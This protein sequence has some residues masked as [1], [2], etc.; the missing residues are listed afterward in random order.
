MSQ[1][2]TIQ[3]PQ[4]HYSALGAWLILAAMV[5]VELYVQFAPRDHAAWQQLRFQIMTDYG[6]MDRKF[7]AWLAGGSSRGLLPMFA[8]YLFVHDGA[9]QLGANGAL[10]LFVAPFLCRYIDAT[11]LLILFLACGFVGVIAFGLTN[12]ISGPLV[13]GSAAAIGMFGAIKFWEFLWIRASGEGWTRYVLSILFLIG[14]EVLMRRLS[15]GDIG[16]E[17]HLGGVVGGILATSV[18]ARDPPH[19][20]FYL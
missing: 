3:P 8:A 6:F 2:A 10:F 4:S 12:D 5:G 13:G 7:D 17:A 11:R 19:G 20:R 18:L 15:G 14:L 1:P 16:A 9:L